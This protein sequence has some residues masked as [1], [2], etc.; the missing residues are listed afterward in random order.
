[1]VSL[2]FCDFAV[3]AL[4]PAADDLGRLAVVAGRLGCGDPASSS[5]VSVSDMMASVLTF[6]KVSRET[7]C[8]GNE[9]FRC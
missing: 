2:P 8:C 3:A 7:K 5:D 6:K 4:D 1:M 9:R